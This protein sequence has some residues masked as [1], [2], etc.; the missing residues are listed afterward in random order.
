MSDEPAQLAGQE[1][2]LR[3]DARQNRDRILSAAAEA[4]AQ[5]GLDIS[6]AA[7]ARR[8]GVGVATLFRRF[9]TKAVLVEEVF[10]RQFRACGELLD[11]ALADPDPWHGFCTLLE[12]IRRMQVGDRGF[13]EA[14]VAAGAS[15]SVLEDRVTFAENGFTELIRRAQE[16]GRLRDDF[17]TADL[18]L[19]L[20]AVGGLVSGPPEHSDAL[21][22]R[23][24]GYL[25]DAFAA[26]PS[27]NRGPL[28]PA[29]D[30][31]FPA[32]V[33]VVGGATIS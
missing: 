6:M 31:D 16:S 19:I 11:R 33:A 5:R 8:A 20:L 32:A 27:A 13:S 24:L 26:A 10:V 23:L 9:P 7:I 25:I 17:C 4:F 28:P 12:S 29:P 30:L 15:G 22:K 1:A 21:S 18:F 14:F 2:D 3:A